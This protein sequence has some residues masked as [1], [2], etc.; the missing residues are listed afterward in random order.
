M[1]RLK[2]VFGRSTQEYRR[3]V[4]QLTGYK[5]NADGAQLKL[6]SVYAPQEDRTLLFQVGGAIA[7]TDGWWVL[8]Y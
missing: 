1:R 6:R 2:E 3:S 8:V 5:I 4:C 7:K